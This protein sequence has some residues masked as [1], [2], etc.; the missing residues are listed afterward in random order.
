VT[1][2]IGQGLVSNLA[3]PGGNITGF[4]SHDAQMMGKWV[5][6]LKEIAPNITRVTV[7]FNP[8]TAPYSSFLNRAIEAAASSFGISVTLAPVQA[9]I[10]G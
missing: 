3:H 1:D 5:Q 4:S 9:M 8:D 6:S 7:I 10:R 2:P